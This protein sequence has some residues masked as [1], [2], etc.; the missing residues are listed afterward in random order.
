LTG[1]FTTGGSTAVGVVGTSGVVGVSFHYQLFHWSF[2]LTGGFTT[3][4]FTAGGS[5]TVGVVGY[6]GV[7]G[8]SFHCQLFH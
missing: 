8:V 5:T 3:G 4:G 7:V 1:G 6:S 2:G